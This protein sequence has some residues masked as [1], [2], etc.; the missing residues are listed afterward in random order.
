VPAAPVLTLQQA[1]DNPYFHATGGVLE[2]AHPQKNDLRMIASP[3]RI[4]G[5]RPE[6]WPA[7]ALGADT[8]TLLAESGVGPDEIAALRADGAI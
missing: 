4:D 1:L 2:L 5:E 7:A 3:I 8:E 6:G